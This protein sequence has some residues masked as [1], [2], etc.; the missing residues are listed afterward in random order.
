MV[1]AVGPLEALTVPACVFEV[2]L[3]W[4]C[5]LS[6]FRRTSACFD[7]GRSRH[8][9]FWGYNAVSGEPDVDPQ[10]G[11]ALMNLR[12]I[13]LLVRRSFETLF[14]QG[15]SVLCF[16]VGRYV[17]KYRFGDDY[18]H[19]A[20]DNEEEALAVRQLSYTPLISVLVPVYGVTRRY[21]EA[22]V[23]SV[24]GQTYPNWQLCLVDDCYADAE[25]RTLLEEYGGHERVKVHFRQERGHISR[26]TN[27]AIAMADG[28]FVAFLDCDD[29]L[30]PNALFAIAEKLNENPEYDLLYSD[31]DKLNDAGTVVHTPFF[32][33]EWSPDTLMSLMYTCHLSAYRTSLVRE[34]GGIRIGV[35]GAQDYDLALRFT[36][37]TTR[38]AHIPKV[39]YHW[40]QRPGSSANSANEK[41]YI[42]EATMTVKK[43]ALERRDLKG[44]VEY[45]K[46]SSLF[47]V[48]YHPEGENR[49]S[50][51]IPS[52]DNARVFATCIDSIARH[53]GSL[54]YDIVVVDNGSGDENRRAYAALC[55]RYGILYHYEPMTFNFS[56]SC[57]IGA[58]LATGNLLLF[59]N[60]DTEAINSSWLERL[61][62]HAL[63]PHAGAVG[64]KLLYPGGEIIQHT[65]VVNLETGPS[66]CL[67]F[68]KD[69]VIH[70]FGANRTAWNRI[71]V[72]GACLMVERKKFDA[73]GG[74]DEALPVD[75]NDVDLCFKLAKSG[76]YNVVRNDAVLY[77]YESLTRGS[78]ALI[79]K[80]DRRAEW[81]RL[82]E[83]NP[84]FYKRDPYLN[85]NLDQNSINFRINVMPRH[86]LE[87]AAGW[88]P[89]RET[90]IAVK[91]R[92]IGCGDSPAVEGVA[93]LPGSFVN[94]W[95]AYT[96]YLVSENGD[97]FKVAAQKVLFEELSV[98]D[99]SE[100]GGQ[101][102]GFRAKFDARPLRGQTFRI[103]VGVSKPFSSRELTA[104]TDITLRL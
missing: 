46:D 67:M 98:P 10:P 24:F 14:R 16:K 21:L 97:A 1:L 41:P 82:Y 104:V 38:I 96:V 49:V 53:A 68:K 65:G 22:C 42:F 45:L 4:L 17:H 6:A 44:D 7:E 85:P 37:K 74:F 75:Y 62:G 32:K 79:Q 89:D 25:L 73:V 34:L 18:S 56:R 12:T 86:A 78:D 94:D 13:P 100:G 84:E 95:L 48:F 33:P 36:E 102:F 35:E 40:R 51:I 90:R 23:A 81:R 15:P 2:L 3:V 58:R 70:Y 11:D 101:R 91:A 27:D 93:Y 26:A 52:K 60:D 72:T 99:V 30:A 64:A 61:A 80:R 77:H 8:I 29:T 87:P 43:D 20:K 71:A 63:L 59:L 9:L 47:Q 50:I 83:N 92:L 28:E 76:Y 39:L 57:N 66:H 31:E 69:S 88:K 55:E 103:G 5:R 54:A 19:W